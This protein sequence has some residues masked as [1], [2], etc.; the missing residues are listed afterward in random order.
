M[1]DIVERLPMWAKAV[2]RD[3]PWLLEDPASLPDDLMEAAAEITEL[4]RQLAEAV[5]IG[6]EQA[7]VLRILMP[8]TAKVM[9]DCEDGSM[10]FKEAWDALIASAEVSPRHAPRTSTKEG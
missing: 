8:K 9:E 10:S 6:P 5:T 3:A 4:R 2:A 1:T 7:V